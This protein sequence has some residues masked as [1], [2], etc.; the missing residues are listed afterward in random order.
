MMFAS[1]CAA[2]WMTHD[3]SFTSTSDMSGPPVTLMITPRAPLTELSSSSG[4]ETAR[5]A[6]CIAR[7]SPSATPVPIIATPMPDMIVLTSAKSRLI[8]PGTRIR[9][10]IPW[11]A[12]RSTSS[13]RPNA[14][15]ID[16]RRST[17]LSRRSLGIVM[18]V[19]TQSRSASRPASAC[20]ARFFPSNLNGLVT[21]PIVSAPS[22]LARL[23]MTGAAPVPVP[24]PRPVVTKIMSAPESAWMILSVSSSAA[25]RPMFGSAP[26]PSPF[27]SF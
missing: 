16:V 23:A 4:L 13:A 26:A 5:S 11:M 8:S 1:S 27:V 9:S 24:P 17:M 22:S 6:A 21:T 12:W 10:E 2:S 7:R 15:V 25:C 3:A 20:C 18:M 19:S 14:S